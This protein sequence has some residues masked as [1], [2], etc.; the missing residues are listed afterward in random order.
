[1]P[2]HEGEG[3]SPI[4]LELLDT[5]SGFVIDQGSFYYKVADASHFSSVKLGLGNKVN[6]APTEVYLGLFVEKFDISVLNS[7]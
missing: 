3:D 1:M 6:L 5:K 4:E 7:D 2:R